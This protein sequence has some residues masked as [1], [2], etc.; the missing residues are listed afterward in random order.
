MENDDRDD[1]DGDGVLLLLVC[2][3]SPDCS[4]FSRPE[5]DSGVVLKPPAVTGEA[6]PFS[7][8]SV[9]DKLLKLAR[10]LLLLFVELFNDDLFSDLFGSLDIRIFIPS[11]VMGLIFI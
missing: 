2:C 6:T 11:S 10:L 5:A 1:G 8:S 9:A 7:C 3:C 4:A